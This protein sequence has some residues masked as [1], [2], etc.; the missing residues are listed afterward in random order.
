[1][2]ATQMLSSLPLQVLLYFNGWFD[3]LFFV[4]TIALYIY[5]G[6]A[7]PYPSGVLGLE[8]FGIIMIA[9]IE[10]CRLLLGSRGNKTET[11]TP[12]GWAL[13]LSLPLFGAHAYYLRFQVFV[14]RIDQILNI[15]A[16][17]FLAI[18][19]LLSPLSDEF[20]S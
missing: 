16:I 7:L 3:V 18:E 5:K 14:L 4:V 8:I 2:P 17:S 15:F 6:N 13:G 11:V 9:F 12:L 19:F 10:P 1:M 20:R